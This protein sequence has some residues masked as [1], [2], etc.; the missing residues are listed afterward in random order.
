[1]IVLRRVS[2]SPLLALLVVLTTLVVLA[3]ARTASATPTLLASVNAERATAGRA[4]LTR[5]ADMDAVAQAWSAHMAGTGALGHNPNYSRQIGNWSAIAE[6][7]AVAGDEASAHRALMNSAGHRTN[8][9]NATYTEVG[10]G[11]VRSGSRVWVTEVFRRAVRPTAP[12]APA[13]PPMPAAP[14]DRYVRNVY[15]DLLSRPADGAGLRTWTGLLTSGT[16]R[17]G[18]AS[19]ITSSA[20][21]RSRLIND[22]YRQ[23][24][25]RG[26]D[27]GGL[28]TWLQVMNRGGTIQ[29]M[30]SG[31]LGSREHYQ[32]NGSDDRRWVAAL[33]RDV[34]GRNPSAAEVSH[35]VGVLR[36]GSSREQVATGFLMSTERLTTVVDGYYRWLLD[37]GLDT[38]GRR[39]WVSAIQSGGR[40]EQIIGGI[41]ASDEYLRHSA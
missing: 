37:R 7:V 39:S 16:P 41:V 26:A 30:E 29:Q 24:L 21:F 13:A 17:S 28:Q 18:V 25:R 14:A 36:G 1:M 10:L 20:E 11:V 5:A 3:P 33:Y 32:R 6:N 40:S 15:Q 12:A 38:A 4:P 31:F 9:L 35:W 22:S 27:A 8:I 23:Y 34:L 2:S 19:S